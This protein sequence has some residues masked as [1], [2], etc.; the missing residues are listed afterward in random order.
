MK[1]MKLAFFTNH[2]GSFIIIPLLVSRLFY[3]FEHLSFFS[4]NLLQTVMIWDFKFSSFGF[5]YALIGTLYYHS[6]AEAEDFWG[7]FDAFILS[8]LAALIFIHIGHFF[9]GTHYGVPTTLPWGITFDTFNIPFIKPIHPVQIYSSIITFIVFTICMKMVRRTHLTGVAG[10][11]GVMLYS[12]SAFGIDFLHGAPSAVS[13]IN[14]LI[15][16]ACGFIFYIDS[17]HKKQLSK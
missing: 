12:L 9:N 8:G 3:I 16:A 1:K 2:F 14:F 5:F 4:E 11:M 6:R 13:K 15:I 7:W 10:S 17:T